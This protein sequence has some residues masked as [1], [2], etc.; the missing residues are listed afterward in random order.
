[1][2]QTLVHFQAQRVDEDYGSPDVHV[3]HV[4]WLCCWRWE[5]TGYIGCCEK[6]KEDMQAARYG[7]LEEREIRLNS[8]FFLQFTFP[9]YT[10]R[11]RKSIYNKA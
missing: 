10:Q 5:S 1:M 9:S 7:V 2:I 11:R 4:F 3:L 6:F 8:T